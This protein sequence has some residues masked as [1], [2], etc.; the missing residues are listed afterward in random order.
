MDI[1]K[2]YPKN[3]AGPFY[4]E[5]GC[6]TAC[7]VWMNFGEEFLAFEGPEA[8]GWHCYF[9]HQPSTD[10]EFAKVFEL[11]GLVDMD[12]MRYRG[13]DPAVLKILTDMGHR[14]ICDHLLYASGDDTLRADGKTG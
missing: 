10:A 2:P 13:S 4:V 6:C 12:C 8:G 7:D 11:I 3:V 5:N 1:P 14:D 9:H